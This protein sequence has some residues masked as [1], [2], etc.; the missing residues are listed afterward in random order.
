MD[1][2]NGNPDM[3]IPGLNSTDDMVPQGLAYYPEKN[4]VLTTSYAGSNSSHTN[5]TSVIY[6]LDFTTGEYVAK[7]NLYNKNGSEFTAHAGGIAV[8][9]NNLYI[10]N[11]GSTLS[12]V[13]SCWTQYKRYRRMYGVSGLEIKS[14]VRFSVRHQSFNG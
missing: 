10:C 2:T 9:N 8:S 1:G 12:Y 4:W 3:I 6:A 7:F 13:C 14:Y 11:S 5:T